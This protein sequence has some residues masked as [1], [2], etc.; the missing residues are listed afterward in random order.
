MAVFFPGAGTGC[1]PRGVTR[2]D[3]VL[4]VRT[5][6]AAQEAGRD[7]GGQLV[8]ELVVWPRR[9]AILAARELSDIAQSAPIL[10]TSHRWG[11]AKSFPLIALLEPRAA[12]EGV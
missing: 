11:K 5:H 7:T 8:P 10:G 2:R 6:G 9:L 1:S 12:L 3:T 4:H